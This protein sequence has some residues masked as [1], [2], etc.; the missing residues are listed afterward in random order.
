[1]YLLDTCIISYFFRKEEIVINKLKSISPLDLSICS[2]TVSEI[3]YGFE[4]NPS[5]EKKLMPAWNNLLKQ[6]RVLDYKSEE[7]IASA[8]IR[9]ILKEKGTPIGAYDVLIAGVA[10]QNDIT[11]VTRNIK[12]FKRVNSLKLE[13]W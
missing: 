7:A 5:I 12:E 6:I 13:E 8:K 1:M 10:L 4:L 2:I 3:I 9:A 11:L